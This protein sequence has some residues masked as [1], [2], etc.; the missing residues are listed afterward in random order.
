MGITS[1]SL[2]KSAI[3]AYLVFML[4][5]VFSTDATWPR[6]MTTLTR[7]TTCE[8]K[9]AKFVLRYRVPNLKCHLVINSSVLHSSAVT[10][11]DSSLPT[12]KPVFFVV[13]SEEEAFHLSIQFFF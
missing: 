3:L 10:L 5:S 2:G 7:S 6:G 8:L 1:Y 9:Q 4:L 13:R 12:A 11:A